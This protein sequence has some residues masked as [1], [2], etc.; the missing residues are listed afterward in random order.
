MGAQADH[1]VNMGFAVWVPPGDTFI[2]D[3]S[4]RQIYD[5]AG[6]ERTNP[7]ATQPDG[8]KKVVWNYATTIANLRADATDPGVVVVMA[9]PC[10]ADNIP[11]ATATAAFANYDITSTAKG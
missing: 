3:D 7:G 9:I 5:P 10:V 6:T 8:S 1:A 2:D 4:Y 11:A